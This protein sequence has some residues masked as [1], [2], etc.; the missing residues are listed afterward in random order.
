MA[1][2]TGFEGKIYNIMIETHDTIK[3]GKIGGAGGKG[4]YKK[5]KGSPA[6]LPQP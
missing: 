1:V 6:M 2:L 4:H 5:G 3:L